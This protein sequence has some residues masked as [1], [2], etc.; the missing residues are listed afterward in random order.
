M[1]E[2]SKRSGARAAIPLAAP[3]FAF[4]IS[5]GALAEAAG[6]APLLTITMSGTTFAGSAQFAAVSILSDGGSV[7]AALVAGILLNA[8]YLPIGI[9]LAPA[10]AGPSWKRFL[11]AQLAVDESWAIAHV[12]GGA[13]HRELLLGAGVT[14]YLA[15]LLGTVLG[16]VAGGFLGEPER[17]GLDAAFPALFLVLL[18]PRLEDRRAWIA[19]AA[20]A[21]IATMLIPLAPPGIPILAAV[22]PPLLLSRSK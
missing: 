5:F 18:A 8:R 16:V 22:A 7:V 14:L 2:P 12:G 10:L 13:F 3:V 6:F 1:Q 4:G 19:A 21:S 15:W 11:G 17:L 9:S 20:G